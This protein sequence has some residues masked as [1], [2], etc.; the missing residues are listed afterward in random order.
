MNNYE[1]LEKEFSPEFRNKVE[2][3]TKQLIADEVNLRELRQ[4]LDCTQSKVAKALG[5][6]QDNVS[7]LEQRSDLLLS[8]IRGYVE[9][10][11]GQLKLIVELPHNNSVL[12]CEITG[13]GDLKDTGRKRHR[14]EGTKKSHLACA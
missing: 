2:A 11:G 10:M 9:A 6:S 4:A 3:R 7:R 5:I 1:K 13:I 14:K 12:R 8:T